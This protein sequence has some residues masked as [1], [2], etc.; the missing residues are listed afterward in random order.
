V[1]VL[2]APVAAVNNDLALWGLLR[3]LGCLADGFVCLTHLTRLAAPLG[4][5]PP[6]AIIVR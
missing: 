4:L 1:L 2:N 3:H 6:L 5:D